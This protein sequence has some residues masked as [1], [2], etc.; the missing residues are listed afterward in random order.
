MGKNNFKK[1]IIYFAIL[2]LVSGAGFVTGIYDS[3]SD[4]FTDINI[5]AEVIIR[6]IVMIL[7]VL[8]IE[9][10]VLM[11]IGFVKVENNRG[12][13]IIT[14]VSSF[15]QYAFAIFILCWGLN[16]LGVNISTI[17]ASI[18]VLALIIGF[19]AESLIEDV[20][21]GLFTIFENQYNVGDI[22]E[23][24][25]YRGTVTNIGIRTTSITDPGGNIKIINNANMKDILNRSDHN[26]KSVCDIQIP[27][28]TD[29]EEFEKVIPDMN[30]AIFDAHTDVMKSV[31]IFLGIQELGESGITLR[32][33]VEVSENDIYSVQRLLNREY[34]LR[35][36]KHGVEVPFPQ[37]DV[38]KK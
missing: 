30:Q 5:N 10:V 24:A 16:I 22:V 12:K 3:I 14:L 7:L 29:F 11:L 18:G 34:L 4:V 26:S 27:Y 19:G 23:I 17:I 9:K 33:V 38:H 8:I 2:V 21:T 31:P 37:M 36:R 1:L 13:T 20:I 35:F 6:I 32:F 28:E 15:I 25:G